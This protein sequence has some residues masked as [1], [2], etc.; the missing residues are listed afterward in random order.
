[1]LAGLRRHPIAPAALHRSKLPITPLLWAGWYKLRGDRK[2]MY[3]V[4]MP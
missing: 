2:A 3:G 4:L 1:M